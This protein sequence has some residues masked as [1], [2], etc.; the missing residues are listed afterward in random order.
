[1]ISKPYKDN[2]SGLILAGGRGS[3]MGGK[4]KG[5]LK[6]AD[7]TLVEIISAALVSQCHSVLINAN[8]NL[9]E[10][11]KL[12][13]PVI[14]D[15]LTDF[16]GPLAGMLTG[17]KNIHTEWMITL[18][19]DGPNISK[20][21]IKKMSTNLKD[22]TLISMASANSRIQPVHLLMHRSVIHSLEKYLSSG[23]RKIDRWV[24]QQPH[25]IIDFSNDAEMFNNLNTPEDLKRIS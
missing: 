12:G 20:N 22:D 24:T 23:D 6:V 9:S 10:Y 21:Y 18:P 7:Q 11:E 13:Y 5:L 1:M 15:E 25:Q 17:L 3:R 8:R 19:C 16:Q 2:I 14:E 4:D